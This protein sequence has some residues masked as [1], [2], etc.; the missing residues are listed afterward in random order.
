MKGFDEDFQGFFQIKWSF[1]RE[2][3]ESE[4]NSPM[5]IASSV[6]PVQ[7]CFSAFFSFFALLLCIFS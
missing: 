6:A 5:K 3:E 7:D 2:E 1:R 4:K